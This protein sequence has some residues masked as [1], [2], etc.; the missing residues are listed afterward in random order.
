MNKGSLIII[1]LLLLAVQISMA[2]ET[3]S[4]AIEQTG[5]KEPV[6]QPKEKKDTRP[7]IKRLSLGG[8]TTFWINAKKTYLDI[9]PILAYHFPKTLSTGIGYRYIYNRNRI[10]GEN[11][12]SYG[13]TVFARANLTKRLYLWTEAEFLTSEYVLELANQELDIATEDINSFFMGFGYIRSFGKR[14]R[15][16]VSFQLLY[17]FLYDKDSNTPY[18]APVIYRVGYFF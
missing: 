13:P 11:L 3:D 2:Q 16:G 1:L 6:E 17:N 8:S 15:G 18:F 4:T 12:N 7:F 5:Q 9:S 10:Y 14:K